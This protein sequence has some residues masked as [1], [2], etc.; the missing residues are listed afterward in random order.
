MPSTA[1]TAYSACIFRLISVSSDSGDSRLSIR[2]GRPNARILSPFS[3]YDAS[4]DVLC[5]FRQ[6]L[7][8]RGG[9]LRLF[10]D[11]RR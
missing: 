1:A 6:L 7:L 4:P 9:E 2:T 11:V 8:I 10:A 3:E 5:Q